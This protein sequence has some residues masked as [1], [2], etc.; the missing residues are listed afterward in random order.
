M[1][2]CL[3]SLFLCGVR[4]VVCLRKRN[5]DCIESSACSVTKLTISF[6]Q[7]HPEVFEHAGEDPLPAQLYLRQNLASISKVK[8][9]IKMAR[10]KN[11]KSIPVSLRY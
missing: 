9:K 2:Q 1:V 5:V 10:K 4:Q 8:K 11:A 3:P 6:C 7:R